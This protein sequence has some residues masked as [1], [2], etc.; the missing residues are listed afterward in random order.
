MAEVS[1]VFD[2]AMSIM[3]EL[4]D[5]GKPQ[6]TDT[7]EYKYR[8]VPIINT[9]IAEL[10]PFSETKKAGKTAS[11][12]RPVE[13]F[14][15]TISEIDNTLALGAMPYG[16]AST[17]LTDEIPEASDRFKRR[18]NE[19]VAMRKANAQCSMGTVEDVYGGIEYGE[20]GSW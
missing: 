2:A 1:D 12:W 15:D 11:G 13:E 4:S 16:L 7:D 19:I 9:M 17:L 10:Y 6:T 20:F 8:T 18:Y 14:D 3:G 5:S